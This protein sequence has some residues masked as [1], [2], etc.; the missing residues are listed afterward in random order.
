M[1]CY[2]EL[3]QTDGGTGLPKR[4]RAAERCGAWC[5][6]RERARIAEQRLTSASP[7]T[8]RH[9]PDGPA[10]GALGPGLRS[11]D[12]EGIEVHSGHRASS[13]ARG[14]G[15]GLSSSELDRA[16]LRHTSAPHVL[17]PAIRRAACPRAASR[18]PACGR[19]LRGRRRRPNPPARLKCIGGTPDERT[20]PHF[21]HLH[22]VACPWDHL[23]H[24]R[25]R[26]M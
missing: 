19:A 12:C 26:A 16:P 8:W 14:R 17:S 20:V 5:F 4:P 10:C 3:P 7:R 2:G 1:P 11:P 24:E 25:W 15:A 22:L 21:S 13:R 9:E 18:C 6:D 23:N